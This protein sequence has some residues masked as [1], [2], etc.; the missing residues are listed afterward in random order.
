MMTTI[1]KSPVRSRRTGPQTVVGIVGGG[2]LGMTLALRH[3]Q[4]GRAVTIIES[5]SNLGGLAMPW[6]LGDIVWDRHYHV[7]LMSD[8]HLLNLLE[9]LGLRDQFSWSTTRTGFYTG[10]RYHEFSSVVDFIK[11]KPLSHAAK[12]RLGIAILYASSIRDGRKL[13]SITAKE[14]LSGLCGARTYRT[15]WEPLLK[16]KI[17]EFAPHVSAAFIWAII[18][19]LYGARRSGEKRELFGY[20][21]GGYARVLAR[22]EERLREL[23]VKIV[24]DAPVRSITES[25]TGLR[26]ELQTGSE[27][28]FDEV[29]VTTPAPVTAR[30]CPTLDDEEI[31]KL[32]RVRYQGIVCASLLV[33]QPLTDYYVTNITDTWVPFSAIVNM[34]AVVDRKNFGG[35]ALVYLPKY[36]APD[37]ELFRLSDDEVEERFVR[38]LMRMHPHF[39]RNTILATRISRV[40]HVFPIT[41]LHYSD[42]VPAMTTSIPGLSIVTAAQIVNGTLNANQTVEL[43]NKAF[44]SLCLEHIHESAS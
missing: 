20:I 40:P 13:E 26:V 18:S 16:A 34:S 10:G 1:M 7:T 31:E 11:F 39:D 9:E 21:D 33:E 28:E 41:T 44:R 43:A 36:V 22:F 42:S 8:T 4:V 27:L 14:W 29:I 2:L 25:A 15:I 35:R 32:R 12:A 5:A 6:Q 24:L 19:R 37:D 3:A 38:A 23:D 30:L 17:G